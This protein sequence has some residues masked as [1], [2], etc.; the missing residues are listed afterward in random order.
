MLL[1]LPLR[2]VLLQLCQGI[3]LFLSLLVLAAL[4]SQGSSPLDRREAGRVVV[5]VSK[6]VLVA[7]HLLQFIWDFVGL[8]GRQFELRLKLVAESQVLVGPRHVP[9]D[10]ERVADPLED[11][12]RGGRRLV[13]VQAA[14]QSFSALAQPL[15]GGAAKP[16]ARRSLGLVVRILRLGGNGWLEHAHTQVDG[17]M[18]DLRDFQVLIEVYMGHH[19][20]LDQLF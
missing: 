7:G 14:V 16:L 8:L 9:V 6:L 4:D 1:R 19:F 18:A 20:E 2:K 12:P 10:Q 11:A 17:V 15:V 5:L 3:L 13:V